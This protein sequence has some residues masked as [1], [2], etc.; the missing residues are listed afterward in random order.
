MVQYVKK[1]IMIVYPNEL[2]TIISNQLL[3]LSYLF[4]TVSLLLLYF[5]RQL[6]LEVGQ[7]VSAVKTRPLETLGVLCMIW[8]IKR[9]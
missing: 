2:H 1:T 5:D 4:K 6:N 7:V 9:E 3:K 8:I